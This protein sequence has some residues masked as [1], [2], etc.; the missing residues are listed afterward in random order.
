[1][2]TLI[3]LISSYTFIEVILLLVIVFFLYMM[4]IKLTDDD[5]YSDVQDIKNKYRARMWEYLSGEM[6]IVEAM[7]LTRAEEIF[8]I[9]A[10]ETVSDDVNK[11]FAMF[12]LVLERTVHHTI[13]E[14]IKTAMRLNGFVDMDPED[15][16]VYVRNKAEVLLRESRKSINGKISYYPTLRGTDEQRFNIEDAKNIYHKIVRKYIKLHR[17]EETDLKKLKLEYSI[18][19]KINIVGAFI[20]NIKKS[21]D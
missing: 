11:Q 20:N 3:T 21:G 16:E 2:Q 5:Y 17:E 7:S 12:S 19:T 13:F 1:M 6:R 15:L 8:G 18:W 4:Y 10:G 9:K 14:S